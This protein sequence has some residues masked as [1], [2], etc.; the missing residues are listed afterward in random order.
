MSLL[1]SRRLFRISLAAAFIITAVL[2]ACSTMVRAGQA[3]V[4]SRFGKPVRVITEPGWYLRWPIPIERSRAVDLRLR[5]TSSGLYSIQ[6]ND[7]SVITAETYVV[8]QVPAIKMP[9]VVSCGLSTIDPKPQQVKCVAY[10][11]LACS[12]SQVVLPSVT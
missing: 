5:S 7:G 9:L 2:M 12:R 10:L 1:T 4:I 3:Q 8:W 6:M 11:A